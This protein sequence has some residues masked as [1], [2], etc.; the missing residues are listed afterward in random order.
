MNDIILKGKLKEVQYKLVNGTY[1]LE[2]TIIRKAGDTREVYCPQLFPHNV[3]AIDEV[4]LSLCLSF[5]E[6]KVKGIQVA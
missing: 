1:Q 6:N 5:G 2:Q 4:C 3:M